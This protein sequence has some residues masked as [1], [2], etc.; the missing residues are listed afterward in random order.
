[1]SSS[2]Q[3]NWLSVLALIGRVLL[4]M[5]FSQLIHVLTM[6]MMG[7]HGVIDVWLRYHFFDLLLSMIVYLRF[8]HLLC[9]S[10]IQFFLS[11]TEVSVPLI[12]IDTGGILHQ[13]LNR[14]VGS[15]NKSSK[16]VQHTH[17]ICQT[18]RRNS[19]H[20]KRY[21]AQWRCRRRLH[22]TPSPQAQI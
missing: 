15:R 19:V 9:Q 17:Q 21:P 10:F 3:A 16:H 13:N 7:C 20:L 12:P 22:G 5:P 4:L 18:I 6:W 11:P 1:M 8:L 14:R 2:C